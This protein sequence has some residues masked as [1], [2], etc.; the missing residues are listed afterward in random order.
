MD[1]CSDQPSSVANERTSLSIGLKLWEEKVQI[2][3]VQKYYW[4]MWNHWSQW[5]LE[6]AT[7][8]AKIRQSSEWLN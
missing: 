8:L 5:G 1:Q 7:S 6:K 4:K 2:V 3:A